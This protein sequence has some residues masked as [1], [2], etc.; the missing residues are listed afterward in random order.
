MFGDGAEGARLPTG[1][2]NV[3]AEY[4]V[5]AGLDG[6]VAKDQLSLLL[7]RPLGLKGVT[8]PLAAEGGEDGETR[9][10]AR[11]NVPLTVLTF[12]RIVSVTD[13]EDFALGFPGVAK[14]RGAMLWDGSERIVHV[15][16]AG[17]DGAAVGEGT[18]VHTNLVAAMRSSGGAQQRF[19]VDT[20]ES[21]RFDVAAGL[22]IDDDHDADDVG[23]K[24]LATLVAAYSFSPR[25][26]AAPVPLAEVAAV[27][28]GVA[29]VVGVDID[30]L[31]P[32]GG[33]DATNLVALGARPTPTGIQPAQL[34]TTSTA[35]ITLVARP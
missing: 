30:V 6:M 5:G 13:Y 4:R 34:L 2:E 15:T 10:Q 16:I 21:M 28:Q 29:G 3:T 25:A 8:N 32:A 22:F 33:S 27:L 7:S 17:T 23:E 35:G 11:R 19:K 24:A 18:T 9:D 1:S 12:E 14:A 31:T 26:L 20:Y